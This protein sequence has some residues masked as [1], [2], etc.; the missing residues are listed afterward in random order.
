MV[1]LKSFVCLDKVWDA[2]QVNEYEVE[3]WKVWNKGYLRK[4]SG[5]WLAK[6]LI[7]KNCWKREQENMLD[8]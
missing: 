1:H 6:K 8:V 5:W 7:D 2:V 3:R 4:T